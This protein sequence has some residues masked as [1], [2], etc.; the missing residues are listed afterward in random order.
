[1]NIVNESS[2]GRTGVRSSVRAKG[3]PGYI[4]TSRM[5]FVCLL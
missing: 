1:M 4:V 5:S 3:D 2:S